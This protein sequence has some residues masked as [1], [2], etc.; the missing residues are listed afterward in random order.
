[1]PNNRNHADAELD[2][3]VAMPA[4]GA[5]ANTASIDLGDERILS[6][7]GVEV[8]VATDDMPIAFADDATITATIQD[9]A[10]N[11][12]F[13]AVTGLSTIVL[14]GT[15]AA[16]AGMNARRKLPQ[17]VRRYLRVNFAESASGGD[18]TAKKGYLKLRF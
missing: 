4:A 6:L 3:S 11:T 10:D 14:T 12:T 17:G 15:G 9:S 2:K 8:V 13:A 5:S 1:M 7:E 16:L 18:I